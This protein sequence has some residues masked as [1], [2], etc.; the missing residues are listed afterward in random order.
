MAAGTRLK[1]RQQALLLR[2]PGLV[3]CGQLRARQAPRDL[4]TKDTD[5]R[6]NVEVV[7]HIADTTRSP[8]SSMAPDTMLRR[9]LSI[10]RSQTET[11]RGI[12]IRIRTRDRTEVSV[13][14]AEVGRIEAV[15]SSSIDIEAVADV[16]AVCGVYLVS[17]SGLVRVAL[18]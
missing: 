1:G 17:F 16:Q 5:S 11:R 15:L 12:S 13:D 4:P 10:Q 2:S 7:T 14:G 18:A 9:Q 6:A 3:M 8:T